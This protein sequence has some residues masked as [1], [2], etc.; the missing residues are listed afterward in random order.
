MTVTTILRL[1]GRTAELT[2]AGAGILG[3]RYGARCASTEVG[4][5]ETI[6]SER[7]R[8]S[9]SPRS[10][11]VAVSNVSI[12]SYRRCDVTNQGR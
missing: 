10:F 5:S 11:D 1:A 2:G 6:A 8:L 7:E 4:R 3:V 9:I 12:A